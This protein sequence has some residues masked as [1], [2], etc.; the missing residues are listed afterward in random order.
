MIRVTS[1][2]FVI[3]AVL[4]SVAHGVVLARM[5]L[6]EPETAEVAPEALVYLELA[7]LG[8]ELG[9]LDPTAP[10]ASALLPNVPIDPNQVAT[11]RD[12]TALPA[13]PP[14]PDLAAAEIVPPE[15]LI[16]ENPLDELP[17]DLAEPALPKP[18]PAPENEIAE[19]VP[20]E[21][22]LEEDPL[23]EP[24][25]DLADLALPEPPPTPEIAAIETLPPEREIEQQHLEPQ[26]DLV[27]EPDVLPDAPTP[28][29]LVVAE[30]RLEERPIAP[31]PLPEEINR[32]EPTPPPLDDLEIVPPPPDERDADMVLLEPEVLPEPPPLRE[33]SRALDTPPPP[34][35]RNRERPRDTP[36]LTV[37]ALAP[38]PAPEQARVLTEALPRLA[39]RRDPLAELP[40]PRA[41]PMAQPK[42]RQVTAA[43]APTPAPAIAAAPAPR[44]A[45][46]APAP[47][48][49]QVASAPATI[50][51]AAAPTVRHGVSDG[52]A[53]AKYAGTLHRKI[54]ARAQR[55]YPRKSAKRGE[56]GVV[57]I[58]LEVGTAGELLSLTVLDESLASGRLIKAAIKAVKK[59]APFPSFAPEMGAGS[60]IFE[61]KILYKLR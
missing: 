29:D 7:A 41:K 52:D 31:L 37:A 12:D 58:R 44:R 27:I 24:P 53:L 47:A 18:P 57:P 55:R 33:V 60:A 54:N 15:A 28:P 26:E 13:P 30:L 1:A 32:F 5:V 22:L 21:E 2:H 9:D 23:D 48:Q 17:P 40:K 39:P 45:A 59:S 16:E 50:P 6:H 49:N 36:P 8:D 61:V 25:P 11:P 3:A 35:E 14:P 42:P 56:E 10:T 20:D 38:P 43:P 19:T 34:P 4:A 51:P 46:P